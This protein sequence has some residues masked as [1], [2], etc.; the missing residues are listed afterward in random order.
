METSTSGR[1]GKE[2]SFCQVEFD[3]EVDS[4]GVTSTKVIDENST[5]HLK[6]QKMLVIENGKNIS[7][8]EK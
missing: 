4:N 3:T 2:S 1:V 5:K 6:M 7:C 8:F